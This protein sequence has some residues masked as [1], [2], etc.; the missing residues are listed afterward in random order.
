MRKA[1]S[2]LLK[3]PQAT[4]QATPCPRTPTTPA[5]S[6]EWLVFSFT[7]FIESVICR[8]K[9]KHHTFPILLPLLQL[10]DRSSNKAHHRMESAG[11]DVAV[12][13]CS[14]ARA[15]PGPAVSKSVMTDYAAAPLRITTRSR[16]VK[17][18]F[19][20][21]AILLL[22][23]AVL[24]ALYLNVFNS[25]PTFADEAGDSTIEVS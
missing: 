24:A 4:P 17:L 13:I 6:I 15:V 11:S 1:S 20:L 14:R 12:Q 10:T 23:G 19:V 8:R 21:S 18:G 9:I 25:L 3:V 2:R 7:Q 16:L 22:F 5:H